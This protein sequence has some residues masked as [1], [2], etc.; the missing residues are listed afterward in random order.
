MQA[1]PV[2]QTYL[3]IQEKQPP[4]RKETTCD[5]SFPAGEAV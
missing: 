1:E 4:G 3:A 5:L 2:Y